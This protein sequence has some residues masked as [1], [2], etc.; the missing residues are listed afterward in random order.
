MG[1]RLQTGIW[2]CRSTYWEDRSAPL[3]LTL[4][5]SA[6]VTITMPVKDDTER[7]LTARLESPTTMVFAEE[8]S[9][10]AVLEGVR[11]G[12]TVVKVN[13][14]DD[15]MLETAAESGARV[16]ATRFSPTPRRCRWWSPMA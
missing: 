11:S 10:D 13:G 16:G 3:G 14:I 4:L 12:R 8:L 1:S 5:R 6:V 15:P 9:V 2:D 7:T